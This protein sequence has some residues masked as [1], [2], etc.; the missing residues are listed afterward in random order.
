MAKIDN[1]DRVALQANTSAIEN[2]VLSS[3]DGEINKEQLLHHIG[4]LQDLH[5]KLFGALAETDEDVLVQNAERP[6]H[7]PS[8][9]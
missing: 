2:A 4:Q 8:I 1:K 9:H 6:A 3:G 5:F 7:T